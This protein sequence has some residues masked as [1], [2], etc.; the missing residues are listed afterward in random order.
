MQRA[1]VLPRPRARSLADWGPL[2]GAV[3]LALALRAPFFGTPLGIDEGGY[4][5]V[6]RA[7]SGAAHPFLYGHFW[8]DRPP[9]LL[10][11]FRLAVTGG[12]G[13]VR[14]AGAVAAAAVVGATFL[15][16]REVGGRRAA[17]PAAV[18]AGVLLGS[19]DLEAVYTP[20]ELLAAVPAT[21][22]VT[23][24]VLAHRRGSVRPV[25]LAGTLAVAAVLIKQSAIDAGVAGVVFVGAAALRPGRRWW[26]AA[27][28][29]GAGLALA[30]LGLYLAVTGT[31][32][33]ALAYAMV[34]FRID[35]L[36]ALAGKSSSF[37][38]RID[39]LL[40]PLLASGLVIALPLAVAGVAG[41]RRDRSFALLFGAW[42][43]AGVAGV[44]AG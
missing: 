5:T 42:L 16:A 41:L 19:A 36:G 11:I 8:V 12:A 39:S 37:I 31:G 21:A 3:G 25:V 20:G 2:A 7:W 27:Y 34:G 35:A 17:V 29:A 18:V 44:L 15:L 22:S 30:A 1:L 14:L 38:G 26:P 28:A 23:A 6:A 40:G 32:V 33:G 4:A 13:G 43:A 9:L 24:L 10:L